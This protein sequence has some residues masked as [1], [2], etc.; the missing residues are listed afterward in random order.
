[1]QAQCKEV[2]IN[3]KQ[4]AEIES[5]KTGWMISNWKWDSIIWCKTY[6]VNRSPEIFKITIIDKKKQW[7]KINCLGYGNLSFVL[8]H[9]C[10]WTFS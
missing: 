7:Y 2:Y 8:R 1:M 4:R 6:L 5:S 10:F 3:C 9:V